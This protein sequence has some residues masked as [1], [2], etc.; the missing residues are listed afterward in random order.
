MPSS[1][2]LVSIIPV[3]IL[4]IRPVFIS[5]AASVSTVTFTFGTATTTFTAE[6]KILN[7][8]PPTIGPGLP[9]GS[10]FTVGPP[11]EFTNFGFQFLEK[12]GDSCTDH[13]IWLA[14]R[15]VPSWFPLYP[16]WTS[17]VNALSVCH[18]RRW[19][20]STFGNIV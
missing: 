4:C 12:L 1:E 14:V 11:V 18:L 10:Q 19:V 2:W 13:W 20:S 15:L 9:V 8:S 6:C 3:V 7:F 16:G 17:N 5:S